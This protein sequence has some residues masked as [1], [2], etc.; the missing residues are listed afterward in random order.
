M[1]YVARE[2]KVPQERIVLQALG[3]TYNTLRDRVSDVRKRVESVA[4]EFYKS[5]DENI[6]LANRLIPQQ[7][8]ELA[9]AEFNNVNTRATRHAVEQYTR[10]VEQ[11]R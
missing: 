8:L 2:I 1:G 6:R 4:N 7:G 9:L 11:Y 10:L 5:V 3:I